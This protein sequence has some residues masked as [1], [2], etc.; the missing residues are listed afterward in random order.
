MNATLA[1]LR[2]AFEDGRGRAEFYRSW[3]AGQS[4]GLTHPQILAQVGSG[5]AGGTTEALRQHLLAGTTRGQGLAELVRRRPALF[6]PF[7]AALLTMA[8]ESGRLEPVLEALGDFFFRQYK[9]MM[10]VRRQMAYPLFTSFAA[11]LI[12]PLPLVFSGQVR[13]YVVTVVLGLLAWAFVGVAFI[14]RRAQRYQQRP[15]FVRAR[16]A[17]TLAMTLDAGLPLGRAVALAASA[18]GSKALEQHVRR[19]GERALVSQSLVETFT[20]APGITPE[21]IASLNVAD[22]TGDVST[23]LHRLAELYE[24]GFK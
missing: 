3:R 22:R 5:P 14:A 24:D 6:E 4:A 13:A 23:T 20:G 16:L 1:G 9:M 17:R 18:S 10:V 19:F 15:A 11:V 8:E 7:E 21:F 2:R 12:A